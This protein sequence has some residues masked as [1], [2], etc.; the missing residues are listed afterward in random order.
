MNYLG[1]MIKCSSAKLGHD[2]TQLKKKAT[3]LIFEYRFCTKNGIILLW[4]FNSIFFVL[5]LTLR[6]SKLAGR[7]ICLQKSFSLLLDLHM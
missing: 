3:S 7:K 6:A 5:K 1:Q 2:L 4:L